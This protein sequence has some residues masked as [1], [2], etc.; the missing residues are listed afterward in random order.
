MKQLKC[1]AAERVVTPPL[2][3][4]IPQCMAP[5]YATG[6][7]DDL[8][9]HALAVECEGNA[10][11]LISIDT[12]GLGTDFT[13]RV[14]AAVSKE[15]GI[16]PT[17]IMVSAIHIHTG[18]PQLLDVFWGQGEDAET[19]ALFFRETV[20]AAVSAY[21]ARVP[22]IASF[23]VGQE[24]RISFCRNYRLTDGSI[25]MNPG[26]KHAHEIVEAVTPI[27][28]TLSVLRFEDMSGKPMAEIVNFACHPD[29]VGG[30]EYSADFPGAMRQN[31]KTVYGNDYTVL[32]FN[33]C[34]GNVNHIDARRF[35]DPDF[36][37][38][39]D[40]YKKMGRILA[41]D[42][43]ELHK[44]LRPMADTTVGVAHRRYEEPRRQPADVDMQWAAAVLA[45]ESSGKVDRR[46]ARELYSLQEDPCYTEQV[47]LQAIRIGELYMVGIPGEP[48]SDL[49]LRL[50]ALVAPRQVMISELA[51]NELG[52]FA[53][54]PA[55][56]G[57]VYEAILPSAPFELS[58]LD[59]MIENAAELVKQ[60]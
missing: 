17:A 48:F 39:K 45:N 6:V 20:D 34:S 2:G 58:V 27:D 7:K 4:N 12:S 37:Y 43:L 52:Y 33:G 11:I 38:P 50:R 46:L 1:G 14:R 36:R 15:T 22:V 55:F 9:T 10:A 59:R 18:G 47:E 5:N 57:R 23:A 13:E 25:K 16:A 29:T 54:E 53:T 3:K 24:D 42:V 51:N 8:Y 49:G 41:D 30:T 31:L 35:T 56:G 40:H 32:F 19:D 60:L 44:R 26:R 21:R 28:P